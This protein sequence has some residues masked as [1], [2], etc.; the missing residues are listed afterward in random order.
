MQDESAAVRAFD[1]Y[2]ELSNV[3]NLHLWAAATS[4]PDLDYPFLGKK[5]PRG[6]YGLFAE[7]WREDLPS[8]FDTYAV[9]KI[10]QGAKDAYLLRFAGPGTHNMIAMFELG[11]NGKLQHVRTL[12]TYH[13][14]DGLCIQTDSW[15]Q[16]FDGDTRLDILQK[17]RLMQYTLRHRPTDVYT[18]VLR[19]QK[20]GTYIVTKQYDID[21]NDYDLH[22]DTDRN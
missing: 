19:Q 15:L 14:G 22:T 18:Q 17:S 11:D 16:D 21:L 8:D 7:N 4:Q 20:D 2:F 5:I 12:A 1:E 6:L 13:C 3:G 9:Y 10:K